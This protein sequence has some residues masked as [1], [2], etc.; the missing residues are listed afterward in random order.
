MTPED[1]LITWEFYIDGLDIPIPDKFPLRPA[2]LPVEV[3]EDASEEK[4]LEVERSFNTNLADKTMSL[5]LQECSTCHTSFPNTGLVCPGVM[6]PL[7]MCLM[8]IY[9][10]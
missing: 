4:E 5:N 7:T 6:G 9:H 3:I 1:V 2:P 10:H 8:T